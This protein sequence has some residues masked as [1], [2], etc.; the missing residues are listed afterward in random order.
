MILSLEYSLLRNILYY[1]IHTF[2]LRYFWYLP[3]CHSSLHLLFWNISWLLK[4][5]L[6]YMCWTLRFRVTQFL[7]DYTNIFGKLYCC[8]FEFLSSFFLLQIYWGLYIVIYSEFLFTN[9]YSLL[10]GYLWHSG[11]L[12]L[13][14]A[15]PSSPPPS[16]KRFDLLPLDRPRIHLSASWD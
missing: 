8:W 16:W 4:S 2:D 1:Y 12:V 11:F 3:D 5:N 15:L 14:C 9:I 10:Y 13:C 7:L 6:R